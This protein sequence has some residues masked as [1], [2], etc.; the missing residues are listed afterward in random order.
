MD[1]SNGG[2]ILMET[3]MFGL[4]GLSN[5]ILKDL[6]KVSIAKAIKDMDIRRENLLDILPTS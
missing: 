3:M 2:A 6:T 1:S 5:R 4:S